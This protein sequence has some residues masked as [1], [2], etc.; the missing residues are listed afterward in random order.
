MQRLYLCNDFTVTV[1]LRL[2]F[3]PK[4][5]KDRKIKIVLWSCR[6]GALSS[7]GWWR[8]VS[9]CVLGWAVGLVP[10]I[11]SFVLKHYH[12]SP[13]ICLCFRVGSTKS[14]AHTVPVLW[15]RIQLRLLLQWNP[16]REW[17]LIAYV[18]RSVCAQERE[19]R[20]EVSVCLVSLSQMPT[21]FTTYV[22]LKRT[23]RHRW[24]SLTH[25]QRIPWKGMLDPILP[26]KAL[27]NWFWHDPVRFVYALHILTGYPQFVKRDLWTLSNFGQRKYSDFHRAYMLSNWST[28][29]AL[30]ILTFS[31]SSLEVINYH[32]DSKA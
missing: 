26:F 22:E 17:G 23:S 2:S 9:I 16:H 4:T 15:Y 5:A 18:L 21:P 28:Q 24:G 20:L 19:W 25:S 14:W 32:K 12:P 30:T 6:E 3:S 29:L 11:K 31:Y 1:T 8:L 7:E 27:E 13:L 10:V